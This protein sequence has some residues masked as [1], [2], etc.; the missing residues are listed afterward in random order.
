M[1]AVEFSSSCEFGLVLGFKSLL[2]VPPGAAAIKVIPNIR[3]ADDWHFSPLRTLHLHLHV[4]CLANHAGEHTKSFAVK[5]KYSTN[6]LIFA[7]SLRKGVPN[8]EVI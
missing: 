3:R 2:A 7:L 4:I 1:L 6:F 8:F 5:A